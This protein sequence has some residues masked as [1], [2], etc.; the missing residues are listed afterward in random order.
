MKAT[1]E[2]EVHLNGYHFP[3]QIINLKKPIPFTLTNGKVKYINEVKIPEQ[4]DDFMELMF[5]RYIEYEG[6]RTYP[7]K[8]TVEL[9]DDALVYPPDW[10]NPIIK[11]FH[12]YDENEEN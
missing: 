3:I 9:D 12:R 11:E 1:I 2:G 5:D 4:M 6:G 10:V 8:I 7:I